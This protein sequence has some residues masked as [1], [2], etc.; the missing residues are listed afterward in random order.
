MP[1]NTTATVRLP[2]AGKAAVL[3]SGHALSVGNGV[4]AVRED[5]DDRVIDTGSGRYVFRYEQV[6]R[7][8]VTATRTVQ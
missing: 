7:T 8:G 2:G 4:T 6:S 3:E 5:V 1:P